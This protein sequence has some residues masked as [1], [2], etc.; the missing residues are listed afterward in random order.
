LKIN[1]GKGFLTCPGGK[2]KRIGAFLARIS[3]NGKIFAKWK[4][5][6][7]GSQLLIKRIEKR[8]ETK[9]WGFWFKLSGVGFPAD[10]FRTEKAGF[11]LQKNPRQKR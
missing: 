2:I 4:N 5:K 8:L 1:S 10:N 9:I 7:L 11:C 3:S 6:I